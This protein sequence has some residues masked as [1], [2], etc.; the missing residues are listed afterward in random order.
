MYAEKSP[1]G[2][3]KHSKFKRRDSEQISPFTKQNFLKNVTEEKNLIS[4]P[5]GGPLAGMRTLVTAQWYRKT[6]CVHL[7]SATCSVTSHWS[8]EM[9]TRIQHKEMQTIQTGALCVCGGGGGL[10]NT[11]ERAQHCNSHKNNKANAKTKQVLT[12]GK[13]K[14]PSERIILHCYA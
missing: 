8:F 14:S 5:E 12:L 4:K 2:L 6:N 11:Y 13:T 3:L 10:S 9:K 1:Q 7:F